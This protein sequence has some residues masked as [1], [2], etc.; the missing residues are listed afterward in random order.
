MT[1]GANKYKQTSVM[2]ASPGQVLIMLYEASIRHTRRAIESLDKGDMPAKGQAIGK[3]HDIVNELV[4]SLN[5]E[6]GGKVAEDL[7]RL[8]N[9]MIEQLLKANLENRRD[10]LESVEKILTNLLEGWRV[11]VQNVSKQ[12]AGSSHGSG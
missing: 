7:E 6:I 5:H 11:A 10:C 3:V 9:F 1:Y 4:N 2:T 12:N 8:Y